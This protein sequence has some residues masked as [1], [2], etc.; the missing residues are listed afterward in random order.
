[1]VEE[2]SRHGRRSL[3]KRLLRLAGLAAVCAL[4]FG[5]YSMW[6]G[7]RKAVT[8]QQAQATVPVQTTTVQAKSIEITRIGLG[9]VTPGRW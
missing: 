3:G 4:A 7:S 5:A 8:A 1:M 6:S 2:N 9:T